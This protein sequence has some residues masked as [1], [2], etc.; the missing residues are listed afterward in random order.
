MSNVVARRGTPAALVGLADDLAVEIDRVM[1]ER[2]M[3]LSDLARFGYS[4]TSV[5]R[6]SAWLRGTTPEEFGV[7]ASCRLAEHLGI[8][9]L[10]DFKPA[11]APA[12]EAV[13]A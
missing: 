10:Y 3:R 8:E 6:I 9:V 11:I 12:R 13:A 1:R 7:L 5:K 2:G 4:E